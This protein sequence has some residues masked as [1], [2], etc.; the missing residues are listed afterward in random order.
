MAD[1][2]SGERGGLLA[3]LKNFAATFIAIAHTRIELL[4]TEIEEERAY[5]LSQLVLILVAFFFLGIGVVLAT[6]LLVV[7]FWDT[8]RCLV[9]GLIT[10]FFLI[11]G[12][13]A[14]GVVWR[15]AR[16]KPRPFVASL[17]ELH[18]DL[19]QIDPRL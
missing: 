7:I 9:M 8:H 19:H 1:K 2:I 4:S 17:S 16:A 10:G 12:L 6:L 13:V 11:A 3:S 15:K 14:W 5:F 18:K